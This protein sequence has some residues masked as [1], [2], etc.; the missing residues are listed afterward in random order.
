MPGKER[1]MKENVSEL[2]EET[3]RKLYVNARWSAKRIADKYGLP[4]WKVFRILKQYG[5]VRRGGPD[6]PI[7]YHR[8]CEAVR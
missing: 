3:L 4:L 6:E 1:G 5:I 2:D 7:N 8:V